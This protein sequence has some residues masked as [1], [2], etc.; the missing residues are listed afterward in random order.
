MAEQPQTAKIALVVI[1]A[2]ALALVLLAQS[3]VLPLGF[4]KGSPAAPGPKPGTAAAPADA[5]ASAAVKAPVLWTRP[6]PVGVVSRD[7]T[8]IE[9]SRSVVSPNAASIAAVGAAEPEY[10]VAGV[11]YSTEQPSSVIINGHVLHEGETVYG[12]TIVKITEGSAELSRAGKSWI[13]KPGETY[14]GSELVRS[15]N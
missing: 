7:P 5:D 3:G 8:R 12:A 14:R 6:D 4:G 11:M 1:L 10:T 9:V 2:V 13:V 15:Q